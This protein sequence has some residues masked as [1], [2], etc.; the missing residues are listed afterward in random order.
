MILNTKC[1]AQE[2]IHVNNIIRTFVLS[3]VS[4]FAWSAGSPD[5]CTV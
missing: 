2:Y 3:N 5:C 4:A 1:T